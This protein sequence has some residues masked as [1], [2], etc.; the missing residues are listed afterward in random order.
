MACDID[1]YAPAYDDATVVRPKCQCGSKR[2]LTEWEQ[3]IGA[4][5]DATEIAFSNANTAC[6]SDN[7]S[8][9][10]EAV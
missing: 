5:A 6:P 7:E 1:D 10:I 9:H 3:S 8:E 2:Q 4:Y